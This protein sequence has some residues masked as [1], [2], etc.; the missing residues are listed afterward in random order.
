MKQTQLEKEENDMFTSRDGSAKIFAVSHDEEMAL[1][2]DEMTQV[3]NTISTLPKQ[4]AAA[5][6]EGNARSK[7]TPKLSDPNT[8]RT[9]TQRV[10]TLSFESILPLARSKLVSRICR[11]VHEVTIAS[12]A[13]STAC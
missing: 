1:L 6:K 3:R 4:I 12:A 13:L 2:R 11:Y 9:R 5:F 8:Q 7:S 10:M